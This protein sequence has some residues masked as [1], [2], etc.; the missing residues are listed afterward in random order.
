MSLFAIPISVAIWVCVDQ[1]VGYQTKKVDIPNVL[2]GRH[3]LT[4]DRSASDM[5]VNPMGNGLP[6]WAVFAAI[7]PGFAITFITFMATQI[8]SLVV[9]RAD[10]KLKVC[11]TTVSNCVVLYCMIYL[12]KLRICRWKMCLFHNCEN[13]VT[14]F[15]SPTERRWLPPGFL[16][17]WH[18][19][20]CLL[21]V[22]PAICDW[23]NY[24]FNHTCAISSCL[25][26]IRYSWRE[27]QIQGSNVCINR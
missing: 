9:N 5:I 14:N 2:E 4:K 8:T 11:I 17:G 27:A 13:I 23:S 18:C 7:I 24:P 1:L 15:L 10:N 21:F 22:G 20:L 19:W 26:T 3:M 16:C 12:A 6:V 25:R